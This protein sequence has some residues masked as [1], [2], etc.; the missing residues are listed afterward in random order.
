MGNKAIRC[1]YF[2]QWEPAGGKLIDKEVF[3]DF[4]KKHGMADITREV[5]QQ[6][7]KSAQAYLGGNA[8]FF[9]FVEEEK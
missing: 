1:I 3:E 9:M 5:N 2:K 8:S 7:K 4:L 6:F